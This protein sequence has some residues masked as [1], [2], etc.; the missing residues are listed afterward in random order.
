LARSRLIVL[1]VGAAVGAA[2]AALIAPHIRGFFSVPTGGVG[3]T[4]VLQYPKGWDYAVVALL[5]AGGFLGALAAGKLRGGQA[6][7]PVPPTR[8]Q[9]RVPVLHVSVVVF[10]LMLFAHDHP[11][12]FMDM[13]HEGEH[14]A[15]ASVYLDG[16]RPYRD[17]FVLHGLATDGGLDLLV[18]GTRPSPL[19]TRRLETV[20]D[21]VALALL[22]P[23]AAEVTATTLGFLAAVLV[24]LSAIGA[25]LVPVFPYYRWIPLLIAVLAVLRYVRTERRRWL[26]SALLASTLGVLWSVEIGLYSIAATGA[27]LLLIRP[28]KILLPAIVALLAPFVVL[29]L[30]NADIHHFLVD[31]FLAVPRAADAIAALPARPLTNFE[32]ETARYYL[33]PV[34]YGLALVLALQAWRGGDRTR[35]LQIAAITLFSIPAFRTAA[36]RCSWSHTR[37]GIPLLGIGVVAFLVEP[38]V[39][40]TVRERAGR[41]WR[42]ALLA[43]VAIPF[44]LYFEIW[45]N[46]SSTAKFIAGWRARQRHEGLVH[47]PMARGRGIYTY[48]E[49]AA[50]LAAIDDLV[51]REVPRNETILDLSGERALYYFLD[52]RPAVRCAD[53]GMLSPPAMTAEALQQ[54]NAHPPRLVVLHGLKGLDQLDGIANR[55]RAPAI[56]AWVDAHY[57]RRV[58]AGRYT[59]ALRQ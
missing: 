23:I 27:M 2:V 51:R 4:T 54:L 31:S 12:S 25:G 45:F 13:Y 53:V 20:L 5:T 17:V 59:V 29:L 39:L 18:L 34:F 1:V 14:L 46:L 41:A 48:A 30:V 52:R 9:A 28:K 57:P 33:P 6:L 22:V 50:D 36:G 44:A 3:A 24:G 43:I 40:A 19:R 38:A 16:G 8:G 58:Q 56:F 7:L 42:I 26:W 21:A 32:W 37:F 11:Y 10:I 47:Y 49:N 15:P 55:D 35:A